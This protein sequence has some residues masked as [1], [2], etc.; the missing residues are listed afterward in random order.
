MQGCGDSKPLPSS[1]LTLTLPGAFENKQS[2][3]QFLRQPSFTFLKPSDSSPNKPR[4]E[5]NEISHQDR[6]RGTCTSSPST[7]P[8]ICC[9]DMGHSCTCMWPGQTHGTGSS[10]LTERAEP[11]AS[12]MPSPQAWPG[13]PRH[14][15]AQPFPADIYPSYSS[16]CFLGLIHCEVLA[17]VKRN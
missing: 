1:L 17:V 10:V 2:A 8:S 9:E 4:R 7:L 6:V 12:S 16:P 15:Q 13:F 3:F 11:A 5:T 14:I